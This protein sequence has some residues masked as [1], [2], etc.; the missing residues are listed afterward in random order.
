MAQIDIHNIIRL[1]LM[2]LSAIRSVPVQD[3]RDVQ[4]GM[5]SAE[6][7]AGREGRNH[8]QRIEACS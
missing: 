7:G 1:A 3:S 8:L 6:K 2:C 4:T 5:R